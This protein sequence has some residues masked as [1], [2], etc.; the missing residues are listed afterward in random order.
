MNYCTN[1]AIAEINL[2][3]MTGAA[4]HSQCE[5]ALT[6]A[7]VTSG[8]WVLAVPGDGN[9]YCRSGVLGIG[10]SAPGGSCT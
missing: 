9:C 10:G 5:I 4:C 7:G 1:G 6:G 3:P 8:C 2:G